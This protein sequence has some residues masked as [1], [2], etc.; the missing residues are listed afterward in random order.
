MQASLQN[1]TKIAVGLMV[2]R[3]KPQPLVKR[4][5]RG[6]KKVKNQIAS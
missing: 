6:V 2:N 3:M 5:K 1:M 4:K